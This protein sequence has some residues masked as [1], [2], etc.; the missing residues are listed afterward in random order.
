MPI[1]TAT[2]SVTLGQFYQILSNHDWY[3]AFSDDNRVYHNGE[4]SKERLNAFAKQSSAH[5][6]LLDGF[7][8][9]HFSGEPWGTEQ[10][11]LPARPQ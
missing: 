3:F 11:P 2:A 6:A 4:A 9:H 5:Q 10:A 1:A 7:S 8:R